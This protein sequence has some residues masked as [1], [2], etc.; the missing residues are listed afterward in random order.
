[1]ATIREASPCTHPYKRYLR[2]FDEGDKTPT[3]WSG[4]RQRETLLVAPFRN[5]VMYNTPGATDSYPQSRENSQPRGNVAKIGT[6]EPKRCEQNLKS[7]VGSNRSSLT[8]IQRTLW[9]K[10]NS[11]SHE[12]ANN[13][14]T[15]AEYTDASINK[16][17]NKADF[18]HLYH[19]PRNF[20]PCRF[21][22]HEI[23]R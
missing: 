5:K 12:Y 8:R 4:R 22:L 21:W 1:M 10:S 3:A 7:S 15:H 18:F 20:C 6:F 16:Q 9:S 14:K 11:R 19:G 13:N 17:T 23:W 2:T